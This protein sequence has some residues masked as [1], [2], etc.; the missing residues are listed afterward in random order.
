MEKLNTFEFMHAI[1]HSMY[2]SNTCHAQGQASL[3][4]EPDV[5]H[6]Q[7]TADSNR[8]FSRQDSASSSTMPGKEAAAGFKGAFKK[9]A[10]GVAGVL[11]HSIHDASVHKTP[12]TPIPI[13]AVSSPCPWMK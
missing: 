10:N 2:T 4:E 8:H 9:A 6:Q 7:A 5:Y 1:L 13:M 3:D 12:Q 11:Q